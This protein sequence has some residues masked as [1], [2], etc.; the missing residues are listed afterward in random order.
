MNIKSSD[1]GT[2]GEMVF[3]ANCY[4]FGLS[5][6]KPLNDANP[7]DLIVDN[8]KKLYKVQIKTITQKTKRKNRWIWFL[9]IDSEKY[10]SNCDI[11]C[12]YVEP[13]NIFYLIDLNSIN[14]KNG[15]YF[16]PEKNSNATLEIFKNKW[17]VF[18]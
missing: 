1:I 14:K 18:S 15:F 9:K 7:Y 16:Y 8:K 2:Y 3:V 10:F 12:V 13:L 5:C 6:S 4:K 17:E 11:L